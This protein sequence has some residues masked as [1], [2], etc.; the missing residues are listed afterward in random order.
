M[1]C[2]VD[3][4]MG[5]LRSVEKALERLGYEVTVSRDVAVVG[6]SDVLVLPGVGSFGD[7][8]RNLRRYGLVEPILEHLRHGKPFLGICLGLQVLFEGSEESPGVEG[9]GVL[10]GRVVGFRTAGAARL[11][12]LKVPHMGW[13]T[14]HLVRPTPLFDGIAEGSR[15]Y[16]V[17][18]YYA[19]PDDVAVVVGRTTYGVT[20]PSLVE[21]ENVVAV[22]FHPE[23]SGAVGLRFLDNYCRLRGQRRRAAVLSAEG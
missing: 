1:V 23:K 17:H 16:F 11:A 6:R 13:N 9:L 10:R 15:F 7:S 22:Q 2:V 18:S 20:F 8:M 14:I 19:A 3:Y 12:R 5:N 21:W 4:G